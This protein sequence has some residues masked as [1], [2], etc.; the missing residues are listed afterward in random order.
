MITA[1]MAS[2]GPTTLDTK[3]RIALHMGVHL[4]VFSGVPGWGTPEQ[5]E[6]SVKVGR[7]IVRHAWERDEEWFRGG[8]LNGVFFGEE[9]TKL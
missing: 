9:N 2:Y 4:I 8:A 7:E 3:F 5:V 6:D 1:F